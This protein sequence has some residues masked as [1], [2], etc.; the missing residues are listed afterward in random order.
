MSFNWNLIMLLAI[1]LS[2]LNHYIQSE[3]QLYTINDAVYVVIKIIY[4]N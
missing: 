1:K 2:V 3:R 4:F